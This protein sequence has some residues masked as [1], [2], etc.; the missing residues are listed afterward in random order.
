[1]L[2]R[3]TTED[4]LLASLIAHHGIAVDRMHT[5][6][7]AAEVDLTKALRAHVD[8]FSFVVVTSNAELNSH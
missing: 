6:L 3:K 8:D 1:M 2:A 5:V 7:M 4:N